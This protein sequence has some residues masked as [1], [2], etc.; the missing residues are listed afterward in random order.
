MR[1]RYIKTVKTSQIESEFD[2]IAK[3]RYNIK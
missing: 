2:K 1:I 3:L